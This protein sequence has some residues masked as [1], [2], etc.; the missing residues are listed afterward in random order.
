MA[1]RHKHAVAG[2]V[3]KMTLLLSRSAKLVN[4]GAAELW[5]VRM[6][7]SRCSPGRSPG[8]PF[9]S[10]TGGIGKGVSKAAG[11][12]S[13]ERSSRR[14]SYLSTETTRVSRAT[15]VHSCRGEDL[16]CGILR[17][18]RRSVGE[19]RETAVRNRAQALGKPAGGRRQ[20]IAM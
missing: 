20:E 18:G 4:D 17:L 11:T 5:S 15:A 2:S 19:V 6:C 16:G 10:A 7:G 9:G 14:H 12:K 8:V 1:D 13:C 3:T